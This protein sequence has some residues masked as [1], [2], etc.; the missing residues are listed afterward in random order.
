MGNSH[1]GCLKR[2]NEQSPEILGRFGEISFYVTPGGTGPYLE[3]GKNGELSE[4]RVS[5]ECLRAVSNTD[6]SELPTYFTPADT[7]SVPIQRYDVIV[8]SALG[9]S[10]GGIGMH[11]PLYRQGALARFGVKP[12]GI[13]KSLISEDC[14]DD[15]FSAW[16]DSHQGIKLFRALRSF[17]KSQIIVQPFPYYSQA[18]VTHP[19]WDMANIYQ[20]AIGA[21]RFY[22][23]KKNDYLVKLCQYE[24]A[25][26][27]NYPN[28][29][30][31]VDCFTPAALIKSTDLIHATD[32]YGKLVLEQCASILADTPKDNLLRV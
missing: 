21:N 4:M 10:L 1:A 16:V 22:Q 32:E 27:L 7:P 19:G 12:N 29:E 18:A 14:F 3:L 23:Q 25:I 9:R 11:E 5:P 28:P 30:W 17:T 31:S 26:L 2:A 20:D 6:I 24:A 15:I 8:L 13:N